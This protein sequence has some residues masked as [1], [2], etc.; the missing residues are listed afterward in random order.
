MLNKTSKRQQEIIESAGKLLMEKGIKGLTTKNLA[1]EMNFSESAI[2][3]HFESKEQIVITMLTFLANNMDERLSQNT[4]SNENSETKFIKLFQN[5]FTFFNANP[6][7][8]VAVFSDGL[9]EESNKIN[10]AIL[11]LMS[12]KIKHLKPII[13]EGQKTEFFKNT[14]SADDLTHIVMGAFR[15]QMYKWRIAN[16]KFDIENEGNKIIQ[17]LLT[18]IK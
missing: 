1:H 8:L 6:H 4:I 5:Q 13:I 2:Y 12:I 16:F 18:I 15:L 7:F 10:E 9:W 3:R 14:I 17:S 11:N